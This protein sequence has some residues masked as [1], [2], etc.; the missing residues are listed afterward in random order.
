MEN[1]KNKALFFAN[2]VLG[3]AVFLIFLSIC[4]VLY[5]S[6]SYHNP[7][8]LKVLFALS[9]GLLFPIIAFYIRDTWKINIAIVLFSI[10]TA[11][12]VM[13]F[14]LFASLFSQSSELN[15]DTRSKLEVI[16]DLRSEG[17][18]AWPHV[19]P[20]AFIESNGLVSDKDRIFPLGGISQKTI[21]YC[22]ESGEY[23]VYESDEHGFNN[24]RGLYRKE[25]IKA[26]LLGDSFT[27]GNCVKPGE[28]IAGRLRDA[29]INSLNLGNGGNGPL[30]EL[31]SIKEYVEPLTPDIVLWIYYEGNDLLELDKEG[32][33]PLLMHYLEDS[34]YTQNLLKRQDEIDE[35][36]VNYVNSEWEKKISFRSPNQLK[37]IKNNES[38][39]SLY[40]VIKLWHIRNRFGLT[41][42]PR[43]PRRTV[44]FKAQLPLFSRILV[45]AH[46]RT[47]A[48]GGKFYFVYL[49]NIER[50]IHDTYY[51]DFYDRDDVLSI[52]RNLHIPLIDFHEA[53]EVHSNPLS[54][55][56][57]LGSHYNTD[58]YKLV[59]ELIYNRLRK[60]GLVSRMQ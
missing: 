2:I 1:K 34:D 25:L 50:Y 12:Y 42:G 38:K 47:A 37:A 19:R 33:S 57:S 9:A 16:K 23:I 21:V 10:V 54:L 32:R 5:R 55:V 40:K 24:P 31:A 28:D 4:Y 11:A 43:L 51:G 26:V 22:N 41:Y 53:L 35:V 6:L 8:D 17:I 58:G 44:S 20:Y 45:E 56:P 14:V 48:W 36:L 29:G 30:I 27:L 60:D 18:N 59:A 3:S 52:V 39:D 13:E 46:Q 7:L 15:V 49:P